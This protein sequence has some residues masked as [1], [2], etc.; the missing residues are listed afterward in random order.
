MQIDPLK[1]PNTRR[2][3]KLHSFTVG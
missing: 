2:I 1:S 3:K